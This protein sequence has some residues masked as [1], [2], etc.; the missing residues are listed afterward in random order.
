[1]KKY[2]VYTIN[3]VER[4]FR[5]EANSADEATRIF[6]SDGGEYVTEISSNFEN[7]EITDIVEEE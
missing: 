6:Y 7:E 1:M 2:L 3:T 5:V 4:V